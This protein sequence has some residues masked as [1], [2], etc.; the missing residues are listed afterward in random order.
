MK[1]I[2]I[3]F[4]AA[5]LSAG[6]LDK[7]LDLLIFLDG[8]VEKQPHRP[9]G[10]ITFADS[11][12]CIAGKAFKRICFPTPEPVPSQLPDR[13]CTDVD[14]CP[15]LDRNDYVPLRLR[16]YGEWMRLC[17]ASGNICG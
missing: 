10:M 4:A 1:L 2:L 14:E 8:G 12:T 6:P 7:G 13:L 16:N 17:I 15:F 3:A 9:A 5:V 11:R